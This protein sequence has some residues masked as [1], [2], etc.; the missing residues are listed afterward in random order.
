MYKI[1]TISHFTALYLQKNPQATNKVS[2]AQIAVISEKKKKI[3]PLYDLITI[4]NT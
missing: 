3:N 1:Q 4:K 2:K